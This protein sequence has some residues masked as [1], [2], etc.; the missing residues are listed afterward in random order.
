MEQ[1]RVKVT[2]R[3]LQTGPLHEAVRN[4]DFARCDAIARTLSTRC[5][6]DKYLPLVSPSNYGNYEDPEAIESIS[7]MVR[8]TDSHAAP[9]Y[10]PVRETGARHRGAQSSSCGAIGCAYRSYLK[11][12]R[13]PSH[14][15]N[16]DL[17]TI[18]FD[19]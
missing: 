7:M 6:T 17:A 19:K 9:A 5:S 18:W 1:D 4:G 15:V 8:E 10:A 2:Q 14:Y 12:G 11:A 13:S 3:V 16:Q